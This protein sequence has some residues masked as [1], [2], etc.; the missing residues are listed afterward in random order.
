VFANGAGSSRGKRGRP[1]AIAHSSQA[2]GTRV[3]PTQETAEGNLG[4]A[5]DREAARTAV[6]VRWWRR[7]WWKP[8]GGGGGSS[9]HSSSGGRRLRRRQW[10]RLIVWLFRV[11][12]KA[13]L[14]S[15]SGLI[16]RLTMW[17]SQ[18]YWPESRAA[19]T[20]HA[21]IKHLVRLALNRNG[22]I[23]WKP[24]MD[25]TA[26]KGRWNEEQAAHRSAPT[27]R[28]APGEPGMQDGH[29]C[30]KSVLRRIFVGALLAQIGDSG[31]SWNRCLKNSGD[32]GDG[33]TCDREFKLERRAP[34]SLEEI[35]QFRRSNGD[36]MPGCPPKSAK[37]AK[38]P[39]SRNWESADVF[40]AARSSAAD[41]HGEDRRISGPDNCRCCC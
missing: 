31:I 4:A 14:R 20:K 19:F 26:R 8:W 41:D 34:V 23:T 32:S 25:A 28:G 3:V 6:G 10:R 36:G 18:A 30:T 2:Q 37:R 29:A 21:E 5:E 27:A 39:C 38:W 22:A 11:G 40:A 35:K 1:V 7:W 24:Q 16:G 13:A 12:G 33:D 9:S 17:R 15:G